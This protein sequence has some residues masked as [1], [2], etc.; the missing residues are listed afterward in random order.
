MIG[1][2]DRTALSYDAIARL[3]KALFRT[4]DEY[5]KYNDDTNI[6]SDLDAGQIE[7][8]DIEEQDYQGAMVALSTLNAWSRT[9]QILCRYAC[10]L[11]RKTQRN[12]DQRRLVVH[13]YG[14]G[15]GDLTFRFSRCLQARGIA[16]RIVGFDANARGIE[17][18]RERFCS[19]NDPHLDLQMA[20]R[21]MS[22]RSVPPSELEDSL[23]S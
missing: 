1:K 21:M 15:D 9:A 17:R 22:P 11:I 8:H 20:M 7:Q 14:C 13:D 16:H 2:S 6:D 23:T 18:G 12:C 3:F 5:K 19:R 4:Y 10:R